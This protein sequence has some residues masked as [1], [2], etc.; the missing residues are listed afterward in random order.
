MNVIP[1]P[2]T[3]KEEK[4]F[5]MAHLE[6]ETHRIRMMES[7]KI[8]RSSREE[9]TRRSNERPLVVRHRDAPK[10]P[11]AK[12]KGQPVWFI[13]TDG[14]RKPMPEYQRMTVGTWGW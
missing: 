13:D 10:V 9:I 2:T 5:S 6:R 12:I 11:T 14:K 1:V 7:K 8:S 4:E 3:P